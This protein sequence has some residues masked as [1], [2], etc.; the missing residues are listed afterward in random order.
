MAV[1]RYSS[2]SPYAATPQGSWYLDNLVLRDIKPDAT[3]TVMALATK[4]EFRP[5]NLSYDL[6]GTKD[7]WWVFHIL[8]MDVIRDPIYDFKAGIIIRIPTK[9]RLMSNIQAVK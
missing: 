1:T 2:G 3:D 7:Y 6:Y 8:N 5:Y 9:D 4:Y